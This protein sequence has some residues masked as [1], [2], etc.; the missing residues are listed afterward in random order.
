MEIEGSGATLSP[1]LNH[2]NPI[3]GTSESGWGP[4]LGHAEGGRAF[5]RKEEGWG[6]LRF[7]VV[8]LKAWRT[9]AMLWLDIFMTPYRW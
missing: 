4:S 9:R 6:S 8:E 1:S 2:V 3:G 7:P 5:V